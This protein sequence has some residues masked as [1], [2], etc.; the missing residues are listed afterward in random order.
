MMFGT[1]P[2]VGGAGNG[3]GR[4]GRFSPGSIDGGATS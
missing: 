1:G 4:G 3:G 2:G